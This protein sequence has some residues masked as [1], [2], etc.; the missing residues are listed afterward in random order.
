MSPTSRHIKAGRDL[1]QI[2]SRTEVQGWP[3]CLLKMVGLA[4]EVHAAQPMHSATLGQ[5]RRGQV[6]SSVP[7]RPQAVDR[8]YRSDHQVGSQRPIF[9]DKLLMQ[10]GLR[11]FTS[12]RPAATYPCIT[13]HALAVYATRP[14]LWFDRDRIRFVALSM[15]LLCLAGLGASVITARQGQ[16]IFGPQLGADYAAFYLAGAALNAGP[17]EQL[18]DI[19]RQ[20]EAYHALLPRTPAGMALPF[21]YAPPLAIFARPLAALPYALSYV[22]WTVISLLAFCVAFGLFWR[23]CPGLQQLDFGTSLVAAAS[24]CPFILETVVGGQCSVLALLCVAL[25]MELERRGRPISAGAALALCLY[26]PTLLALIIPM[27]LLTGRWRMLLGGALM[28]IALG[29]ISWW[30]IGTQ[31]LLDYRQLLAHYA[32]VRRDAPETFDHWKYVDFTI[33]VQRIIPH[34]PAALWYVLAGF[35]CAAAGVMARLAWQAGRNR[36]DR[37]WGRTCSYARIAIGLGGD[38]GLYTDSQHALRDLRYDLRDS[39]RDADRKFPGN[40]PRHVDRHRYCRCD[41]LVDFAVRRASRAAVPDALVHSTP[42]KTLP[43]SNA[44]ARPRSAWASTSP[45]WPSSTSELSVSQSSVLSR[46]TC[47]SCPARCGGSRPPV[48]FKGRASTRRPAT[49]DNSPALRA[50]CVDSHPITA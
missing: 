28:T 35:G 3:G 48:L 46:C 12:L 33:F 5:G 25:S 7:A 23:Q 20:H 22:V 31:G 13:M 17:P 2:P 32:A 11:R 1:I 43:H 4:R 38:A 41:R 18:Y 30:A 15:V 34:P 45:A 36:D 37:V 6:L 21:V 10:L 47:H 50:L 29:A 19:T 42:G 24:F 40:P 26:K 39:G 9:L 14:A 16:T 49:T 8:R 44:D 27:L